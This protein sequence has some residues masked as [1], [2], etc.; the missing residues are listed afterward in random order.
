M[1]PRGKARA[2]RRARQEQERRRRYEQLDRPQVPVIIITGDWPP[3]H[4]VLTTDQHGR[5]IITR[6]GTA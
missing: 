6:G 2:R 3:E 4:G 5:D 1:S